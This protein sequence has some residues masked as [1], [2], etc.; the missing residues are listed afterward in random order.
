MDIAVSERKATRPRGEHT[1]L[2]GTGTDGPLASTMLSKPVAPW[3]CD[4]ALDF[5]QTGREGRMTRRERADEIK[6]NSGL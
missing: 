4:R 2:Q 6:V 3:P 1:Q 5:R